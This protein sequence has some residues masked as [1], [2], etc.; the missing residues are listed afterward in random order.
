MRYAAGTLALCLCAAVFSARAEV[1]E[2]LEKTPAGVHGRNDGG[3]HEHENDGPGGQPNGNAGFATTGNGISYHGGPI[4]LG[5]TNVYYIWYGNWTGNNAPTILDNLITGLSGSPYYNINTTYTNSSG[6]HVSNSLA[7][8]AQVD[9]NYS[10]G[11][12]LSDSAVFGVVS[13]AL[14]SGR[15]P[16]DPN[17]VYFVL[18]SQDVDETSGFCTQYCG[19]HTFGSV[20]GTPIKFSFVGNAA[21]CLNACAAQSTSPNGNAGADAMASIVSHELE[22]AV[23]DPQLNAWFDSRGF[24]N[25]DKCA[26][27]FGATSVASNGSRYNMVLNGVQYLIQRNWVNANGGF[28]A[29]KFP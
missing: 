19:W 10:R 3:N 28:C 1:G 25:A 17:G 27:T 26:W 23:T 7:L 15:L 21:R 9:D 24:E 20:G 22:E 29:L 4:M 18:T 12:S 5:T 14:T 11:K 6:A 8:G 13:S 16:K 2:T